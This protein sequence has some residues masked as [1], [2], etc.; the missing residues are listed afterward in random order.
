MHL[1]L[2]DFHQGSLRAYTGQ[3]RAVQLVFT[4]QALFTKQGA[5]SV[6]LQFMLIGEV[7]YL[8]QLR[9]QYI[10]P[11]FVVDHFVQLVETRL[12]CPWQ[13]PSSLE[14]TLKHYVKVVCF[15]A[16]LVDLI[17]EI[18]ILAL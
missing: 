14:F 12:L 2:V 3:T 4:Q 13:S 9:S 8:I 10:L 7:F 1:L 5:D 16:L 15:L 6:N 18:I 11:I 17:V